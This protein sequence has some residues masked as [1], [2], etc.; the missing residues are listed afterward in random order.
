LTALCVMA[1]AK[2]QLAV[3]LCVLAWL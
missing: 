3:N 2:T 1:A